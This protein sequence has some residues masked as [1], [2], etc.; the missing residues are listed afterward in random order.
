MSGK[1]A[2][3]LYRRQG[4]K[5][6]LE[7]ACPGRVSP[8]IP[9]APLT[10]FK[11]GGKAD[12][13]VRIE[14]ETELISLLPKLTERQVPW[15]IL[16]RGSNLLV[17]DRGVRGVVLQL[18]PC[19]EPRRV[20]TR[21]NNRLLLELGSGM[22]VA[23]LIRWAIKNGL[24]GSEFL[25][26]IPGS[27]GGAW[28]MNAGSHGQEIKDLTEYLEVFS[29]E[30]RIIKKRKRELRFGYRSL[31]LE[32][33]EIILSGGLLLKKGDPAAVRREV[34]RLWA[35]RRAGQPL[36]L[37]SCGSVFRNP[38]GDFAGRLIEKAGLKGLQKG[39]AQIS[40][41]HANFI[42]N[43]GGARASE[44]LHLINRIRFQVWKKFGVLLEPE[45]RLW[46]LRLKAL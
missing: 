33:G 13:L 38:P 22:T 42:V 4:L 28:A 18:V 14:K 40:E 46:G 45:V 34:R 41:R 39:G 2:R 8:N 19:G 6:F 12:W 3:N 11:I 10:T 29:P 25:A 16:G 15:Q 17:S 37:P 30:G 7:E 35:Q 23:G 20:R 44:V 21:K 9:L 1:W 5:G 43:K 24:S 32:P 26:G 27:L 31:E 36:D